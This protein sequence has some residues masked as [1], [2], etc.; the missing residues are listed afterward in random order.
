MT[1]ATYDGNGQRVSTT[2][3]PSGQSAI[4]QGYVWNDNSLLMDG[5][6]AYVY[7]AADV[8]AE[9]VSLAN[10]TVTYLVTDPLQSVRGTVNSSGTLTGATSYDAWGNPLTTGG[11]TAATPFGFAGGYTDPDGLLYLINRYYDPA[12]G[13]FTSV[14]PDLAQTLQPY[15][16]TNGDPVNQSDPAGLAVGQSGIASWP[17]NAVYGTHLAAWGK[18]AS[19]SK[20]SND[21]INGQTSPPSFVPDQIAVCTLYVRNIREGGGG[22]FSWE[23]LLVCSGPFGQQATAAQ[24]LRSSWSGP[25]GYGGIGYT[26]NTSAS[27]TSYIWTIRC[28]RGHGWY[29]YR[30]AATG[31]SIGTGWQGYWVVTAR[32]IRRNCGPGPP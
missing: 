5:T 32:N 27:F 26:S 28:N 19:G 7:A 3:T 15:A 21:Y 29:R 12:T 30:G 13:Q 6:K 11:L 10:G 31:F 17:L 1:A 25:R 20:F 24:L 14:D 4:T 16:Y 22:I 2:I 8:P 23:T 18:T 9:Q